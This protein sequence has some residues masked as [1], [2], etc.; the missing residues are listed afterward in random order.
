MRKFASFLLPGSPVSFK[1]AQAFGID[2][3]H[4]ADHIDTRDNEAT[5]LGISQA[6]NA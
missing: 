6:M 2:Q 3:A 5:Q 4:L 1:Q